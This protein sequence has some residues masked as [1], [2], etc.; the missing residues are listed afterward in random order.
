[1]RRAVAIAGALI[2]LVPSSSASADAPNPAPEVVP[3][4]R[5]WSGGLGTFELGGQSRIVVES[6]ALAG[7]AEMLRDELAAVSGLD[8]RVVDSAP[9]RAGDVVLA[10]DD[11]VGREG[12]RLE[13]GD[14]VTIAGG[15][16]GLFYGT[17]TVLQ[18]LRATLGHRTLPRG[19]A[20]DWPRLRE[21]GYLLDVGRKYWSPDFIV[22]TIREMAYLKLNT[23]HLHFSDHNAFRLV[24]DRFPYLT[25]PEAYT[26]A[27]IRRFEEVARRH[28]VMLIPEVEMP[29]HAS[30]I[31]Q[32]HP[33]ARLRVCVDG[34]RH[35]G[36]DQ[37]R[38]ARVLEGADRR[39]RAAVLRPGVH[40][41][42]DEYPTQGHRRR[43]RSWC[44][45]PKSTASGRPP[46]CS[47]ITSTRSTARC[48]R[49][50]SRW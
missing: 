42:T 43:A 30:A 11:R 5:E 34:R 4:L 31:L 17:Q 12:Y 33:E 36:C 2:A 35:A 9:A 50:A 27:D 37:A 28:H 7:E 14:R 6:G 20:R 45:T 26:R 18:I 47:W 3:A 29:S 38:G 21:R 1:M 13:I 40:I 25:A 19:E 39:V 15:E 48:A 32:V 22:Q 23:L 24:S 10:R 46:T 44:A 16:A 8:V 49:T 41:A